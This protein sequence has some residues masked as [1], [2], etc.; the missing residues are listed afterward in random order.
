MDHKYVIL[1]SIR[2]VWLWLGVESERDAESFEIEWTNKCALCLSMIMCI[3]S[4][5]D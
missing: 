5:N 2:D 3:S 4:V 1:L